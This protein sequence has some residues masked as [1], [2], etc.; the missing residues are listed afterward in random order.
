MQV[1]QMQCFHIFALIVC[2]IGFRRLWPNELLVR[3]Y[4]HC[5]PF[6]TLFDRFLPVFE[7]FW[8]IFVPLCDCYREVLIDR[9]PNMFHTLIFLEP[10]ETHWSDVR[11]TAV[12]ET[13]SDFD[14]LQVKP[15]LLVSTYNIW[16]TDI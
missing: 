1:G 2:A 15:L 4:I 3:N 6:R 8:K 9:N 14:D 10:K 7:P 5:R 11:S 16:L 13:G 12:V